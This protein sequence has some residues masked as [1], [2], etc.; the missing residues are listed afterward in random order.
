M[1]SSP[2]SACLRGGT[3]PYPACRSRRTYRKP[4]IRSDSTLPSW[5]QDTT[6]HAEIAAADGL[7]NARIPGELAAPLICCT[8]AN[9]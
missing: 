5:L 8:A 3:D 7:H 4:Q 6:I 2:L 9:P 1:R